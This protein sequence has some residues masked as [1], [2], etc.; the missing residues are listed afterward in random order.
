MGLSLHHATPN[1]L[2]YQRHPKAGDSATSVSEEVRQKYAGLMRGLLHER[3]KD[4]FVFNP[5]IVQSE[6]DEYDDEYP[7]SYVICEGDLNKLA[8]GKTAE[9][10]G[11]IWVDVEKLG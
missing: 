10:S 7:H 3:F 2:N 5:I 9:L 1:L 11:L 8:P 4:E 6:F